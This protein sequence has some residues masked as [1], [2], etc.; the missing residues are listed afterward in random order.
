MPADDAIAELRQSVAEV[1]AAFD[2]T[3]GE[4]ERRPAGGGWNAWEIAYHL[5]D[6][7]RWYVAKLCEAVAPGKPAALQRFLMAWARLRDEA[8]GLAAQLPP[9]RMDTPGLL[10]GVPDW[11]PRV[12]LAAMAGHDHEHAAQVRALTPRSSLP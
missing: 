12:L 1:L 8:L 10:T 11:T 9:E 6:I 3:D 4:V 5:L 2:S 7:E